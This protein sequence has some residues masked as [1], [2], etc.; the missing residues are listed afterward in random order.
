[1]R[2]LKSLTAMILSAAVLF[3]FAGCG[4]ETVTKT[5]E[6]VEQTDTVTEKE[7]KEPDYEALINDFLPDEKNTISLAIGKTHIPDA[8]IWLENGDGSVY[9]NNEAVATVSEDG[10]VTAIG[11][12]Q[13]YIIISGQHN[14]VS[15]VY[16]Y[17]VY[18]D[19]FD[20][21][22]SNLPTIEGIDFGAE[23][24]KFE[25]DHLNTY[26]LKIGESHTPSASV[27]AS[28]GTCYT[29]DYTV[30]TV[31]EAGEVYAVNKGSA[32]VIIKSNVGNL[33]KIYKYVVSE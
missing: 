14:S 29:S 8:S 17:D 28:N 12:G 3:V 15:T 18:K 13:A 7:V 30:A 9:T 1:M 23:I 21:D 20:A 33:F 25:S 27:W 5:Q 31:S 6:P 19:I 4:E 24:A 22:I 11:E 10:E 32:Y 16:R 26:E 2:I